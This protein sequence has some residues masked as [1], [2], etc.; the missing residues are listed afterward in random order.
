MQQ[1]LTNLLI[2]NIELRTDDSLDIQPYTH[3][4]KIEKIVVP[5]SEELLTARDKYLKVIAAD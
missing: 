5:L 3:E 2:S 1:V 4:R